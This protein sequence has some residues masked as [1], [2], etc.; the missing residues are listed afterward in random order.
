M[1][2]ELQAGRELDALVAERIGWTRREDCWRW[3]DGRCP[4]Q[5]ECCT[6]MPVWSESIEDALEILDQW[7]GD[8]D[9]RRQNG[10]YHVELFKPSMQWDA[11]AETL[12][13]A[14][15]RAAVKAYAN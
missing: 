3:R 12:P 4:V 6:E 9:I 11:W 2:T 13:L 15:C 5:I 14:I 7:P 8:V 1:R 10:H